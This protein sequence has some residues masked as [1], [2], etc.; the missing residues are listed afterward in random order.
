MRLDNRDRSTFACVDSA[1]APFLRL[2]CQR[3][4]RRRKRLLPA[5]EVRGREYRLPSDLALVR[6]QSACV[7]R[8][9]TNA[10]TSAAG[11][12]TRPARHPRIA[13]PSRP[14]R[15][16]T[17]ARAVV[18]DRR[19][20]SRNDARRRA[21]FGPTTTLLCATS[22]ARAVKTQV[23]NVVAGRW[24]KGLVTSRV[25]PKNWARHRSRK[26][27]GPTF[28]SKPFDLRQVVGRTPRSRTCGSRLLSALRRV[29]GGDSRVYRRAGLTA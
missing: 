25:W 2:P 5:L 13:P 18:S 1:D 26:S 27:L 4:L 11:R 19:A 20:C 14:A 15:S 29:S 6:G 12:A 9:A 3:R 16:T 7:S 8:G 22:C 28:T 17:C 24:R 21:A 10:L 23:G